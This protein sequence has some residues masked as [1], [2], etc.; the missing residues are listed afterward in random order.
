MEPAPVL[1]HLLVLRVP[2]RRT[3]ALMI[4]VVMESASKAPVSVPNHGSEK[5]ATGKFVLLKTRLAVGTEIALALSAHAKLGGLE[6][7]VN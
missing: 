1:P 7:S 4:A 3:S 5:T 2:S 6:V